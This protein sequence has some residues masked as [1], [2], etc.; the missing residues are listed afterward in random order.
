MPRPL[1]AGETTLPSA[2]QPS[3][4]RISALSRPRTSASVPG[5][6]RSMALA[7]VDHILQRLEET[8]EQE[9]D[10]LR[11]RQSFDLKDFNKRKSHGLLELTRALR[12]LDDHTPGEA[13][14]ARIASL[15]TKLAANCALLELHVAAVRE[16]AAIMADAIREAES[17][18]TYSAAAGRRDS[19]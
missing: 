4:V 15:R 2:A 16:V 10:A 18:G 9:T 3:D 13:T 5:A 19:P 1:F 12:G 6:D 11:A 7:H 17:D 8:V 14:M